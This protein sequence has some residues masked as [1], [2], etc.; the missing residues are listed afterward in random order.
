MLKIYGRINSIN[1]MKVLW[2]CAELGVAYDRKDVGGQFGGNRDA[3]YLSMNPNAVI[4]TIDDDGFVL[5]E[6]NA[7]VRYLA[8]LHGAGSLWPTDAR[9]RASADRWMDWQQTVFQPAV[10]PGFW[11]LIRTPADQRDAQVIEVSRQKSN[12][13]ARILEAALSQS[14]YVAGATFTMGDIPVGAMVH[15]WLSLAYER[16]ATPNI[17]RYYE[18]LSARPAY[19]THIKLPLS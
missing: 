2:A 9:A 6:S 18:R 3:W 10:V 11:Q 5:W 17:M 1:V 4:P 12:D 19:R 13:A 15:R 16:P 8:S 7:I 14:D